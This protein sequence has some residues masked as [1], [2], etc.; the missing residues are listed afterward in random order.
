LLQKV[1]ALTT[2]LD[3]WATLYPRM[4]DIDLRTDVPRLD[5]P[6]YFV[7]GGAEMHSMAGLFATWYRDLAA[8]AK[9]LET[10]PGAG[11]RVMF[12]EPARI[13]GVLTRVLDETAAR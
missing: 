9:H 6:V 12:E 3:T 5:V 2:L 13:A 10:V 4:Q 8:P 11:H 1:H 7:Q